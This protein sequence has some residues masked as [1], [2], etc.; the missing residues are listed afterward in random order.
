M[1]ITRIS[2]PTRGRARE[3]RNGMTPPERQLWKQLRELKQLGFHFRR[4][5]PV[6]PFIADFAELTRKLIVELDGDTH[7]DS[8][9]AAKDVRRDQFLRRFGFRILRIPNSEIV[10]N[11]TGVVEY[12]LNEAKSSD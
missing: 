5:A 4:Q 8:R 3:L 12:I 10:K 6:G 9:A 11:C 7:A 2:M 1:P